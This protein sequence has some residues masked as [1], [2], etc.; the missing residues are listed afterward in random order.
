MLNKPEIMQYN[1]RRTPFTKNCVRNCSRVLLQNSCYILEKKKKLPRHNKTVPR[2][3][4]R[5]KFAAVIILVSN[6]TPLPLPAVISPFGNEA[7][8]R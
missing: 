3:L 4:G 2:S 1:W 6:T 8:A 7:R 5:E